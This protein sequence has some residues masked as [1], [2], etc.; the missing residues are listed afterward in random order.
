MPT[1]IK[2]PANLTGHWTKEQIEMREKAQGSAVRKTVR[3]T[4]PEQVKKN[5]TAYSYWRQTVKLMKGISLLDDLDS[6][7]LAQYC[8]QSARRDNLQRMYDSR[9]AD[10]DLLGMLQ[11]QERLILAYAKTL[12]LTPESRARLAKKAA[13]EKTI[14]PHADLFD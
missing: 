13:E 9:P 14:D 7:M 6:D 8:L 2:T 10:K 5:V 1:P 12:G 11:S 4:P 3:L